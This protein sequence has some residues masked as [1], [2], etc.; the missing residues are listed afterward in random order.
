MSDGGD[1]RLI[2]QLTSLGLT[3]YEAKAYLALIRRDSYTAAQVARQAALPRQ[4]IYDVLGSLVE[5]GLATSRPGSV[6]KYAATSPELAIERLLNARRQALNDLEQASR[7]MIEQ[8]T[9]DFEAGQAHTDP[10]EYIEVLRDRGAINERF[11]ELQAAIKRE[12][13]VFTK[14]PYATPPQENVEGLQVTRTHTARSVYE[15]SIFD[16]PA[17]IEGVR[18]F[19]E[20]GEEARFVESLPLKLVIID[21]SIVMFGMEDPV[22]GSSDLTIVVVEHP[23]L[24]RILKVAFET[25]WSSGLTFE[26][27]YDRLVTRKVASA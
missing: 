1:P 10:L 24:A 27:A 5:K 25:V 23:S 7:Q 9:P 19:L 15:F 11:D 16:D 4:R 8:L 6:V 21:E 18:R 2:A 12:I 17:T 3:S 13:L 14:P 26:Q 22:A 20:A